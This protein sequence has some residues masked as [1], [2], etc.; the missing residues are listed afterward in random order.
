MADDQEVLEKEETKEE[1]S[2]PPAE[3]KKTEEKGEHMIPK[4]RLDEEIGKVKKLSDRLEAIDVANKEAEEKR[5][6]DNEE[7][8]VLADKHAAEIETLK[9][10]AE[11]AEAQ[12]ATLNTYLAAQVEELPENVRSM[13]PEKYTTLEKLDWLAQNRAKLLK[14]DAPDIGAFKLGGENGHVE[15]SAEEKEAAN[16]M[17]VS[18]KDYAKNKTKK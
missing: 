18:A 16:K 12:E 4:S 2:P 13:I 14:P 7:Y 3:A 5:L 6:K 15:L 1:E 9:P 17:G 11:V 10:K 8:K